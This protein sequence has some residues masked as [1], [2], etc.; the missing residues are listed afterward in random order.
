MRRLILLRHAKA[1][2][3][4]GFRDFDRPLHERGVAAMPALGAWLARQ[5]LAPER[6]L[7]STSRRTRETW[8]LIAPLVGTGTKVVPEARIYEARTSDVL[9]RVRATPDE[10]GL[11]MVVGHN[12]GL[13]ELVQQL[14]GSGDGDAR[15]K[16]ARGFP[17]GAVAV[18]ACPAETW[19]ELRLATA[20]LL[21]FVTPDDLM[22]AGR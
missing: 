5:E 1:V 18:L 2:S 20:E 10:I 4:E 22:A 17:P 19:S 3:S 6:A 15:G 14:I 16:I 8:E 9:E 12:P 7:V 13:E 11:L 21:H